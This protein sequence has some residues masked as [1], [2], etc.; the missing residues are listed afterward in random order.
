MCS[1]GGTRQMNGSTLSGSFARR[2]AASRVLPTPRT[3]PLVATIHFPAYRSKSSSESQS[4]ASHAHRSPLFRR[5]G[6][7]LPVSL[8]PRAGKAF[9]VHIAVRRAVRRAIRHHNAH[10]SRGTFPRRGGSRNR[11]R[12]PS[13]EAS[14]MVARCPAVLR[15]ARRGAPGRPTRPYC[16]GSRLRPMARRARPAGP[17]RLPLR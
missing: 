9:R 7:R 6:P 13:P 16:E 1:G 2:R 8:P 5:T 12:G 11:R 14:P 15:F 10:R 3:L 4:S 17:R